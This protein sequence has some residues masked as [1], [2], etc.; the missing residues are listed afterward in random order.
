[1]RPPMRRIWNGGMSEVIVVSWYQ[2]RVDMSKRRHHVGCRRRK[3]ERVVPDYRHR[4][5]LAAAW[6]GR[7]I[8][9]VAVEMKVIRPGVGYRRRNCG[10][11][12]L[13]QHRSVAR[14]CCYLRRDGNSNGAIA[15]EVPVENG[16]EVFPARCC[17]R[18]GY[19]RC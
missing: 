4:V 14:G 13:R 1:M 11:S 15:A 17:Y 16:L 2:R 9:Y 7:L 8:V 6:S 3:F 19:Y 5:I 12:L 18:R 10:G